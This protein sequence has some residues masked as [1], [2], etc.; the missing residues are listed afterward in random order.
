MSFGVAAWM[1]TQRQ[2]DLYHMAQLN[3]QRAEG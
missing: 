2:F 1:D 3:A